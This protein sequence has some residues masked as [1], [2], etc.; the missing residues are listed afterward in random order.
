MKWCGKSGGTWLHQFR[1]PCTGLCNRGGGF[2]HIHWGVCPFP[3]LKLTLLSHKA[4]SQGSNLPLAAKNIKVLNFGKTHL[5]TS[6]K[7]VWRAWQKPK[8][9]HTA[10]LYFRGQVNPV[11]RS[12]E[13]GPSPCGMYPTAPL[14]TFPTSSCLTGH[15]SEVALGHLEMSDSFCWP[16]REAASILRPLLLVIQ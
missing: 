8:P 2:G 16:H 1:L 7:S 3:W 10:S 13:P 4:T 11:K 5:T 12:T 15:F 9:R 6:K 14:E